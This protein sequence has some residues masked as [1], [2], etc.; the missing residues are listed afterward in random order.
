LETVLLLHMASKCPLNLSG[1]TP[2]PHCCWVRLWAS[3]VGKVNIVSNGSQR[4]SHR[5]AVV[6]RWDLYEKPECF[7]R[8]SC[9]KY[10]LLMEENVRILQFPLER[11][12]VLLG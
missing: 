5:V 7:A 10:C 12:L 6:Y 3:D 2:R 9:F 8:H 1:A 11:K 4:C